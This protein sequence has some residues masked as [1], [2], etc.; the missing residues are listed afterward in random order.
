MPCS[1]T[2]KET[3]HEAGVLQEPGFWWGVVHGE[4]DHDHNVRAGR[5]KELACGL[6][7]R[8]GLLQYG[9]VSADGAGRVDRR[10]SGYRGISLRLGAGELRLVAGRSNGSCRLQDAA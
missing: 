6:E 4:L 9:G 8:P 3:P 7:L 1:I 10:R 2:H 5:L